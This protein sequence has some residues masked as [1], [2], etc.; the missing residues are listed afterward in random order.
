MRGRRSL[1]IRRRNLQ[2]FGSF[3]VPTTH[4]NFKMASESTKTLTAECY[5]KSTRF[6][7]TVPLSALPLGTHLCSCFICRQVHG[8]LA[9]F[10]APLPAGISPVFLTPSTSITRYRHSPLAA[11]DRL[12]CSTCG[13]HIGDEDIIPDHASGQLEWRVA[14]SIFSS[15]HDESTFQI[16]SHI[17]PDPNSVGLHTWLP[18]VNNRKL[19]SWAP[20]PNDPNFP[21]PRPEPPKQELDED[22]HE[23][24][25]AQCHC[26]GVSFT[27]PRPDHPSLKDD[28]LVKRYTSPV[29]PKKWV[30]CLDVCDDCRLLTGAHVIPWTFIPLG[31]I[32][33]PVPENFEGYG[34]L[35]SY[36]SSEKV[37]RGFCGTCGATVFYM[38]DEEERM[39]GGR[40]I[41]DLAV[42]ILRAP[43]GIIAERWLTWRTGRLTYERDGMGY[44]AGFTEGLKRGLRAWGEKEHGEAVEFEI[45]LL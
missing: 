17:F 26:S 7:V 3:P 1:L 18:E 40:R 23:L 35:K 31:S 42:G 32:E 9:C 43:E 13:C 27:F 33:P 10:H 19:G 38:A 30:A 34:T 8:T 36:R 15:P 39:E 16:R 21:I 45:P 14:T 4:L 24:L 25:R 28:A 37:L 2:H 44:D 5:C 12:F 6:T 41:V 29:D 22:G 11:S 20:E